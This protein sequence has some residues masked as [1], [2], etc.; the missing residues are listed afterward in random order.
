MCCIYFLP[1]YTSE[2]PPLPI[3]L[4]N[5]KSFMQTFSLCFKFCYLKI[6]TKGWLFSRA[7]IF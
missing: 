6:G 3:H 5:S 7:S 2:E 4:M 1:K